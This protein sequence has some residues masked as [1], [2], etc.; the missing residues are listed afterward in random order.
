MSTGIEYLV[1]ETDD[2]VYEDNKQACQGLGGFLPEPRNEQENQFLDSLGADTFVLGITDIDVEGQFVYDSDGSP[3]TWAQWV[4]WVDDDPAPNGGTREN[5]VFMIREVRMDEAGYRSDGWGDY[6]CGSTQ[7]YR[8][9]PSSLVCQRNS[10]MLTQY[11]K[12][13]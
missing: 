2:L 7:L 6:K 12:K 1:L 4:Q 13:K 8:D 9:R 11:I 3:V 5:C 10:G